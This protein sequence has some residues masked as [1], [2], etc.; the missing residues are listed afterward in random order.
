V[1][2]TF[3]D[4]PIGQL[5]LAGSETALEVVGFPSGNKARGADPNWERNDAPFARAVKQL[6][7]YFAG[8]RH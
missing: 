7:E 4:S 1:Y 6:R 5:M 8:D 2:Y 3:M